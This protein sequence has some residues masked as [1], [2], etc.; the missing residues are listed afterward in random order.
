MLMASRHSVWWFRF[1]LLSA[2]FIALVGALGYIVYRGVWAQRS[3]GP[4]APARAVPNTDV[5]PYGANFFLS[6]E[7]EPWKLDRT[8]QMAS[9]AGIGWVKQQFPWEEIEPQRKGEYL[10]PVSKTDTWAKYDKIVEAC[11]R[12]GLQLVAR[13]DRPPDWTRADNTYRQRPPDDFAD[14]GDFVYAVVSRYAGRIRYIQVWNEPNIFPEW[15]NQPVDPAAYAEL[16]QVA[17]RRAKEADPNI[18]VLSAPLA[19]TLGQAHPEP[20]KWIAMNDLDYLEAMYRAGA[21][22][23]FDIYSANAFGMDRPPQDPPD[24]NV[25]NF[26]R[27]L[28]QREIMERYGDGAK[29]IWFNEYGWNAAPESFAADRLT[30]KRVTEE[31]QAEYTLQG[32]EMA[33][34]D[35]PWAG[36]F[37]IW[38]FRQVGATAPDQAEYYF[39]LVDVDFTP[40]PVYLAVQDAARGQGVAGPGHYEETSPS[41]RFYGSW[42]NQ[43]ATDASGGAHYRSTRPGDSVTFAFRGTGVDLVAP[44]GPWAGRLQVTLDGRAVTGLPTEEAGQSYVELYTPTEQSLAR[45]PLV[46]G[47]GPG[48]HTL[49]LTISGQRSPQALDSLCA[50]DS[51]EVLT[52]EHPTLAWLPL[53]GIAA[54]L[55]LVGWLW[56]RT[57]RRLR[58]RL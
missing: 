45:I 16:L 30:W 21:G 46:R 11:E 19:I 26:Q 25:L 35:W 42:R 23:Y 2:L 43:I 10:D 34:R 15:G 48:A 6:R 56:V 4:A 24:P 54:G 3:A 29:A 22:A 50:V 49:R 52:D 38:Y 51:F 17:Y 28:L 53:I 13:L 41:V 12:Y 27:V 47:T 5:N 32:I 44:C 9:E 58:G 33:R 7:V 57:W 20:G 37:M 55:A 39:R 40:R 18:Y 36:V 14:Y 1:V 31:Q 8:L